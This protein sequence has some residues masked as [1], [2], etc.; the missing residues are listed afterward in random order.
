VK[1][2]SYAVRKSLLGVIFFVTL[3]KGKHFLPVRYVHGKKKKKDLLIQLYLSKDFMT[4][5]LVLLEKI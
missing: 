3:L 2:S 5:T 1:R 4:K